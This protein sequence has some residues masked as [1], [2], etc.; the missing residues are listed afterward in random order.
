VGDSLR[1][2]ARSGSWVYPRGLIEP[3]TAT[4][5]VAPLRLYERGVWDPAKQYWGELDG[6]ISVALTEVILGGARL[7]F[8]F[9]QL[10][11]GGERPDADDAI[12]D[13]LELRDRGDTPAATRAFEELVEWDPRCLDAHAH[14][15]MLAFAGGDPDAALAHYATGVEIAEHA[16]GEA[17]AGVL[18]W[19]LIDNRPFLRCLHGLTISAWRLGRHDEAETL[20]WA[21]LW[22]NPAD[23]QGAS[24]LLPDIAAGTRWHLEQG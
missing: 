9:E 15:G 5:I 12:L 13:A 16:I 19:G 17:F 7:E 22:L 18:P 14:L 6:M 4:A 20:C 1:R 2:M 11:P 8:E 24:T 3:P 10:L 23:N 21:L